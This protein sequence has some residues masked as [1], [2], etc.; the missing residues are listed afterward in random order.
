MTW[1]GNDIIDLTLAHMAIARQE[2]YLERAFCPSER[3]LIQSS[4]DSLRM[5]WLLWSM[6]ESAYKVHVR[7]TLQR[8]LNPIGFVCELGGG[9]RG[10]VSIDSST[11]DTNSR[12]QEEFIHTIATPSHSNP[13]KLESV[14]LKG[15]GQEQIRRHLIERVSRSYSEENEM[16]FEEVEFQKDL[17][18]F[19][20]VRVRGLEEM[21]HPCSIS[22]HGKFGA[23]AIAFGE[24]S[25]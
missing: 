10:R 19:P 24:A 11:Y 16:Q 21:I 20:G 12:V 23:Y 2:R 6:K 15:T 14:V 7:K 22:H 4:P 9:E 3:D 5:L 1:V 17:H 13:G 25:P 8:K 18:G